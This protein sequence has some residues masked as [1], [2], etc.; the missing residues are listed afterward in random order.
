[1]TSTLTV[2]SLRGITDVKL[3]VL[4]LSMLSLL[5]FAGEISRILRRVLNTETTELVYRSPF[6]HIAS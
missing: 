6:S 4:D 2:D 3:D 1:M 5:V